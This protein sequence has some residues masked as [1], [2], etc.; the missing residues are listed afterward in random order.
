MAKIIFSWV[1]FQVAVSK[2]TK[3]KMQNTNV[4]PT[5]TLLA[6]CTKSNVQVGV[7]ERPSCKAYFISPIKSTI[8][9]RYCSRYTFEPL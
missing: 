6:H 1:A 5:V 9:G 4:I 2:N 8:P 3:Y 7:E